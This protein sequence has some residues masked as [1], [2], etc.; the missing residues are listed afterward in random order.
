MDQ[1]RQL[2]F[3]TRQSAPGMVSLR[4]R[5]GRV[6][7]L[8][9]WHN[10]L[11]GTSS[12][13]TGQPYCTDGAFSLGGNQLSGTIPPEL[14]DLTALASLDLEGNQ[15]SGTIPTELGNLTALTSLSL[16]CNQAERMPACCMETCRGKRSRT[17]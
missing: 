16:S 11:S 14:G 5:D 17:A 12:T 10:D 6:I 15:L 4:M 3:P 9:L 8:D 1:Q 2:V 13:G 7:E